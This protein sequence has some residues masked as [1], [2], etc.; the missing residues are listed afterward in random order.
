[1]HVLY[2]TRKDPKISKDARNFKFPAFQKIGEFVL[3]D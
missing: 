1:M 2:A 3:L